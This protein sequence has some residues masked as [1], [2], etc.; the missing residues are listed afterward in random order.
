MR[1]NRADDPMLA[2]VARLRDG[3]LGDLGHRGIPPTVPWDGVT[4]VPAAPQQERDISATE[5]L[6]RSSAAWEPRRRRTWG[7][8]LPAGD[9]WRGGCSPGP[10]QADDGDEPWRPA[11]RQS[12]CAWSRLQLG[13][14]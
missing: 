7:G 3:N 10:G 4:G 1:I 11:A 5:G 12:R 6:E 8:A 2:H 9:R 14:A 13:A